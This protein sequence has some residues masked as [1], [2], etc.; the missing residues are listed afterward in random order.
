MFTGLVEDMGTIQRVDR[1]SDAAILVITPR[2]I[3]C[4][5]LELGESSCR[6]AGADLQDLGWRAAL[7][8]AI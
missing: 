5:E 8:P 1:R 6:G 4:D 2:A 3:S 7:D